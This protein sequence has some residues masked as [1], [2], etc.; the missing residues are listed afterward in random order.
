MKRRS[1]TGKFSGKKI[2]EKEEGE[3]A[4]GWMCSMYDVVKLQQCRSSIMITHNT[5]DGGRKKKISAWVCII[6]IGCKLFDQMHG[7]KARADGK[8]LC[9]MTEGKQ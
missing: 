8:Q 4:G 9:E 5:K 3:T 6:L 2:I 1:S 7:R